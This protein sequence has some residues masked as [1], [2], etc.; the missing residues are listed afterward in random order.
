MSN[1]GIQ[2]Q[3]AAAKAYEGLFVPALFGISNR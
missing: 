3:I 1:S 2:E